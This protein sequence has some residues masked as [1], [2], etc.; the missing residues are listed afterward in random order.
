ME[1]PSSEIR[2]VDCE[3]E[4]STW[5]AYPS[6]QQPVQG[7][8]QCVLYAQNELLRVSHQAAKLMF[9]DRASITHAELED[10]VFALHENLESW[11]ATLSPCVTSSADSLPHLISLQS[12]QAAS[13]LL[14]YG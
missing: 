7:H 4:T 10:R 1:A 12:V 9:S 11:A 14:E 8:K 13:P 3:E 2:H 6:Q 5:S